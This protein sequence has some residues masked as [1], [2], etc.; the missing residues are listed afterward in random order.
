MGDDLPE[1]VEKYGDLAGRDL[2]ALFEYGVD[3]MQVFYMMSIDD[4][5]YTRQDILTESNMEPK[6][7]EE[8]ETV[9]EERGMIETLE[10]GDETRYELNNKAEFIKSGINDILDSYEPY[11]PATLFLQTGMDSESEE[12]REKLRKHSENVQGKAGEVIDEALDW[13]ESKEEERSAKDAID[14]NLEDL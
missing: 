11:A 1:A 13:A 4:A 5:S 9:L 14:E 7:L 6:Q 8:F 2:A 3:S 12:D 10:E